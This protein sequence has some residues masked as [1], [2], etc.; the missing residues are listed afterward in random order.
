MSITNISTLYFSDSTSSIIGISNESLSQDDITNNTYPLHTFSD[1]IEIKIGTNV[2]QLNDFLFTD[3]VNLTNITIYNTDI[4]TYIGLDI[5]NDVSSN[6]QYSFYSSNNYYTNNVKKLI[7]LLPPVGWVSTIV[8]NY[9]TEFAI[10]CNELTPIN[11]SNAENYNFTPIDISYT[12]FHTLFFPNNSYFNLNVNNSG[13]HKIIPSL[14]KSYITINLQTEQIYLNDDLINPPEDISFNLLS[15]VLN[16]YQYYMPSQ[17]WSIESTIQINKQ[18]SNLKTIFNFQQNK[19]YEKDNN[20]NT[21]CNTNC[22]TKNTCIEKNNTKITINDFFNM[23]EAQGIEMATDNSFNVIP[24]TAKGLPIDAYTVKYTAVLTLY[25]R[26]NNSNVKD[27]SFKMP[28]LINFSNSM[29]KNSNPNT[30]NYRYNPY[31]L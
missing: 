3:C 26:S 6:G 28:Y 13:I 11:K 2:K 8:Y 31:Y 21:K 15:K 7:S 18:L 24:I 25:L 10:L 30:N 23:F 17:C 19:C 1:I 29:P 4:I 14:L 9:Y 16:H 22:N 5:F 20:C 12:D 27:I